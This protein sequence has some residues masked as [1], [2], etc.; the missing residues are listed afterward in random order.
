[1]ST[2]ICKYHQHICITVH[3]NANHSGKFAIWYIKRHLASSKTVES[4]EISADSL[5]KVGRKSKI[6]HNRWKNYD[7][8]I[9]NIGHC[10]FLM[11][12]Y[13]VFLN[14]LPNSSFFS[15]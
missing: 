13:S 14:H 1:M 6:S 12:K 10:S 8:K 2:V 3:Y 4:T 9:T 5:P 15:P 11:T 7:L